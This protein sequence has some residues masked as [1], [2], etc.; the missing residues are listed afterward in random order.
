MALKFNTKKAAREFGFLTR[1]QWFKKYRVPFHGESG[2]EFRGEE[3]F[4]QSQT[5][6]L[7]SRS[8]GLKE[9]GPLKQGA[10][11][12]GAKRFRTVRFQV[13][14]ESDFNFEPKV[15]RRISPA[16][17]IDLIDAIA[18]ITDTAAKFTAASENSAKLKN[19]KRSRGFRSRARK[20]LELADLGIRRAI[21]LEV[22]THLGKRGGIH[23]YVAA[24]YEFR[25]RVEPPKWL[26][27]QSVVV[28]EPKVNY[29]SNTQPMAAIDKG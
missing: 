7:F 1:D 16:R 27:M 10:Q 8:K 18:K 29:K 19:D 22:I 25:S 3:Y 6:E 13:Y 12:V 17:T 4:R 5:V 23:R 24:G 14:R 21:V 20:L 28:R 9:I 2:I 15:V 26:G 11:S